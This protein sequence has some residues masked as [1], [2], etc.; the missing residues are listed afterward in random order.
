MKNIF[1]CFKDLQTSPEKLLPFLKEGSINKFKR[2]FNADEQTNQNLADYNSMD[3]SEQ[4]LFRIWKITLNDDVD[5]ENVLKTLKGLDFIEYAHFANKYIL[6][7]KDPMVE[8]QWYLKHIEADK[9]WNITQGEGDIVVAVV[10]SGVDYNHRDLSENMWK[11]PKTGTCGY[12]ITE[13]ND[14]PMDTIGHGTHVAGIIGAVINNN[15]D[16]AGIAKVKIMAVKAYGGK[17][18]DPE[19]YEGNLILA[20]RWA[21]DHGAKIINNSWGPIDRSGNHSTLKATLHSIA[22]KNIICV[23]SSGND[24]MNIDS[25][26]PGTSEED[27]IIVS[28]SNKQDKK[29]DDSN[30][31]DTVTIVAPG[32]SIYSLALNN[33]V[34]YPMNGTSYAAP[35]VS[36]AIALLLSKSPNIKLK[37][38]KKQLRLSAD[39]IGKIGFNDDTGRL[40]IHKLLLTQIP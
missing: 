12:N 34:P 30:I 23:F 15:I 20:L 13:D 2:F 21:A 11:S 26:F 16:I 3:E 28:D 24:Y 35:I 29:A 18:D 5:S 14:D 39:K 40:N 36:G 9:A 8:K 25:V 10:D 33:G 37:E 4:K 27:I 22:K 19:E 7:P 31:G 6:Q 32:E 38:I 1:V 17:N